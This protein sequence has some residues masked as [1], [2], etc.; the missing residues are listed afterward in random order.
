MHPQLLAFGRCRVDE[1]L[2]ACEGVIDRLRIREAGG[3]GVGCAADDCPALSSHGVEV[4]AGGEVGADFD[5][6]ELSALA[7]ALEEPLRDGLALALGAGDEVAIDLIEE[8]A[9]GR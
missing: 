8:D 2:I 3:I 9:A 7:N 5:A 1:G 4:S 6:R